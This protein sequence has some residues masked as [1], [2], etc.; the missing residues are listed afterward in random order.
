MATTWQQQRVTVMGLGTFGGGVGLT[1]YLVQQGAHV[2][3]HRL[4]AR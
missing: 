2:T 1:R 3:V 4:A